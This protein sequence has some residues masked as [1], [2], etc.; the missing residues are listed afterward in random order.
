MTR[1]ERNEKVRFENKAKLAANALLVRKPL[2]SQTMSPIAP[3]CHCWL[4][5]GDRRECPNMCT[6]R[7]CGYSQVK[8]IAW[9]YE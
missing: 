5:F 1:L 8:D 2:V 9:G 6:G 7:G 4:G 3:E